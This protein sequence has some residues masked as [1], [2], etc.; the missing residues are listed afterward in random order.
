LILNS[1]LIVILG[2]T[3]SGKSALGI[4][5]AKKFK[6]EIISADSRQVYK[7]MDL[8]TGKVT[9]KEQR[10]VPHHLLNI[11]NPKRKFTVSQFKTLADKAI[12]QI[13]RKNKLPFLVG[14]SAFYIY[15]VIDDLTI[16]EVKP[17]VKLRKELEKKTTKELFS[18]LNKLDPHRAK[19][20]DKNNPRRLIR[21]IEIIKSTGKPIPELSFPRKRESSDWIPCLSGRQADQV[22]NDSVLILGI[23]NDKKT[24]HKI[25]DQR[26]KTRLKQGMIAEI[27]RLIKQGV[28]FNRL[29]ELGL[30]YRYVGKY[31][32]SEISYDEMVTQI[33]KFAVRQ[34]TWFKRD[35]RIHWIINQKEAE[36]LLLSSL[37]KERQTFRKQ[38]S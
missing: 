37:R 32:K 34:M 36:K 29:D 24:L 33:K 14:G 7:G 30:E 5:L 9:K 19:L 16:P 1:K 28:S 10:L 38:E 18:M 2:P 4:A 27:K 17:N 20:I 22:R 21:A 8:G 12:K 11:A 35:K 26:L 13:Q 31:L 6:G 23:T 15:A 3:S 25:I